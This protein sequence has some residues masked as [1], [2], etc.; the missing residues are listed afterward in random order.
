M[1]VFRV[2]WTP[3]SHGCH[4]TAAAKVNFANVEWTNQPRWEQNRL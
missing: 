3:I 2:H 4:L 1:I